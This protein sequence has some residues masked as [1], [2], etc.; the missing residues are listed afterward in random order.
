V[1]V[2]R[3]VNLERRIKLYSIAC[4]DIFGDWSLEAGG[5]IVKSWNS[6]I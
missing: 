2:E 4:I 1:V 5:D 3:R 6:K